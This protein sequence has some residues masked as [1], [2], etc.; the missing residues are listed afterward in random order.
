MSREPPDRGKRKSGEAHALLADGPQRNQK[1]KKKFPCSGN[2]GYDGQIASRPRL[3]SQ[4][5]PNRKGGAKMAC[6][7]DGYP[8]LA[9]LDCAVAPEAGRKIRSKALKSLISQKEKRGLARIFRGL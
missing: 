8:G 4:P 1:I 7:L 6:G 5:F 2:S 9:L 3:Y